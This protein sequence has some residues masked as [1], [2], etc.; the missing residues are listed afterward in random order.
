MGHSQR[1]T[2]AYTLWMCDMK[3][4]QFHLNYFALKYYISPDCF[5]LVTTLSKKSYPTTA[6]MDTCTPTSLYS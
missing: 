1:Q 3:C 2:G 5:I 4:N 6:P